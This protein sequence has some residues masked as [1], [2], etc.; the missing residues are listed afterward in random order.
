MQPYKA[1]YDSLMSFVGSPTKWGIKDF[2]GTNV[3]TDRA[4][5]QD[6]AALIYAKTLAYHL[7]GNSQYAADARKHILE[8][9]RSVADSSGYSGGN[10]CILT[11]A[12]HVPGYIV[13]ADLLEDYSGWTSTDKAT[14]MNW[15]NNEAY[16]FVDWASE[17]RSTNWGGD[18]SAAAGMIADYFANSGRTLRDRN[19]KQ[20][21]PR[22]AYIEAKKLQLHRMNGTDDHSTGAP[23]PKM[24]NSVCRNFQSTSSTNGFAHGIQAHGGI[25]EETGR[26]TTGCSGSRLTS[27]DSAWTYMH[28][29]LTGML[30]HA[31]MLLRRGDNSMYENIRSDGRGSLE[32]ALVFTV[33]PYGAYSS[34]TSPFELGYRYYKNAVIGSAIGVG[35]SRKI[36]GGSNTVFLHFGTLT[37]GFAL[38][39]NPAP[40]PTVPAP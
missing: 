18:A 27:D 11:L 15:L 7:T 38:N 1:A 25:P 26:G 12:R 19:G 31:E 5:M 20:W 21:S 34:R 40:P 37:H 23:Y 14:L 33:T 17:E 3:C 6:A 22:D 13:S 16:H 4:S 35:G 28:T 30:M 36:A 2:T 29:T 32:K 24:M 39:E 8:M 10:G 9:A